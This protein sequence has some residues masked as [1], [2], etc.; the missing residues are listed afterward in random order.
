MTASRPISLCAMR[1]TGGAL[2]YV[3][4]S[5]GRRPFIRDAGYRAARDGLS[6]RADT[7]PKGRR[8]APY[9]EIGCVPTRTTIAA[10]ASWRRKPVVPHVSR[11]DALQTPGGILFQIASRPASGGQLLATSPPGAGR[12]QRKKAT[13]ASA[14]LRSPLTL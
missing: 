12:L 2:P 11:Q 7:S 14:A 10:D 6:Q 8:R 13:P 1:A 5:V 4:P 9:S 3:L